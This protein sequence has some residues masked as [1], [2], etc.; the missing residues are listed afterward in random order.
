[1]IYTDYSRPKTQNKFHALACI[2]IFFGILPSHSVCAQPENKSINQVIFHSQT[3]QENEKRLVETL[4]TNGVHDRLN[5]FITT[6]LQL[7]GSIHV[8]FQSN[9]PPPLSNNE[10]TLEINH[11]LEI[12]H[13]NI[14]Q[15]INIPF[16]F[17]HQLHQGLLLKYPQQENVRENIYVAAAEK[18]LWFELG[19]ALIS[20]YALPISGNEIFTLDNFSTLM[21]LNQNSLNSDYLLD[22]TEA[23]LLIDHSE[24]LLGNNTFQSEQELDEQRYRMVVCLV[25]GKDLINAEIV[26][27]PYTEILGELAWDKKRLEQCQRHYKEKLRSWFDALSPKLK[28][29]NQF[30]S[31]L[32]F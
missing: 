2:I 15:N 26:Q 31:W 10:L 3:E 17:L 8:Y 28:K 16:S 19:R 1:M 20:Q 32:T 12:D 6:N 27:A 7:A 4:T 14:Q 25:L 21:L 13:T 29:N 22:A 18:R 9:T 23:Y 24:P 5:H 30:E 11:T